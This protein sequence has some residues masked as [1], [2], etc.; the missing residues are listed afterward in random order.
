MHAHLHDAL[1]M[2]GQLLQLVLHIRGIEDGDLQ[3]QRR[4][5]DRCRV[6]KDSDPHAVQ[7]SQAAS[8]VP[9]GGAADVQRSSQAA[10]GSS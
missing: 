10:A 7:H 9:C 1:G 3:A 6:H 2:E 8:Q 4:G 5:T